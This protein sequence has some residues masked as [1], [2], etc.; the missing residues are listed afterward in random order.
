MNAFYAATNSASPTKIPPPIRPIP[1]PAV[2][3]SASR[4]GVTTGP[5]RGQPTPQ[6][7]TG[8]HS[9]RRSAPSPTSAGSNGAT[10]RP[11]SG[12]HD[13]TA[14]AA[15]GVRVKA[16]IDGD[17]SGS[18]DDRA[19]KRARQLNFGPSQARGGPAYR[20]GGTAGQV[21]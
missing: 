3:P 16:E 14:G 10:R 2:T 19:R 7:A 5:C 6:G 8:P 4:S 21:P 1:V 18:G 20:G 15:A 12:G 13:S 11:D 9:T 17:D